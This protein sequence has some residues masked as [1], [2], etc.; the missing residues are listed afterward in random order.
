MGNKRIEFK[1]INN[2]IDNIDDYDT[3]VEPFC[4]SSAVSFNKWLKY[5]NNRFILNDNYIELMKVYNLT[6]NEDIEA[7]KN[8]LLNIKQILTMMKMFLI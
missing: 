2:F 8:R 4:G 3:I 5:P 7:I 1:Y 6:E